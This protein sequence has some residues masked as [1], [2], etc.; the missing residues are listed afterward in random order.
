[1]YTSVFKKFKP[2]LSKL[3]ELDAKLNPEHYLILSIHEL[4]T[5]AFLDGD[6]DGTY[7]SY[8]I[9]G[10]YFVGDITYYRGDT[11]EDINTLDIERLLDLLLDWHTDKLY[12][13]REL[14]DIYWSEE[15]DGW[16]TTLLSS[17][18]PQYLIKE[19]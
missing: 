14:A 4:E 8:D 2:L 19:K 6:Q 17:R 7:T 12:K 11:D 9:L 3:K 16:I 15:H 13:L 10:A 5:R 1:M 18:K